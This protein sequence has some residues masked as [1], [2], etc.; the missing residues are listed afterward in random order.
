[1][2]RGAKTLGGIVKPANFLQVEPGLY[3]SGQPTEL[4]FAELA[5]SG[6]RTLINLRPPSEF[7]DF[8]ERAAA[9]RLGMD[10]LQ[11]AVAGSADLTPALV[12]EFDEALNRARARGG[13]LVYCRSGNRVGAAMALAAAWIHGAGKAEALALGRRAG[14]TAMEASISQ[15]IQ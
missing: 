6:V 9:T 4:E 2:A 15:M 10:Y 3:S 7:N 8:D 11:M 13:V 12:R 14:L 5:R 1:M